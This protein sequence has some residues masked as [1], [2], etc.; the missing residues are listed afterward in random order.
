MSSKRDIYALV[1][2]ERASKWNNVEFGLVNKSH[3]RLTFANVN[4][5]LYDVRYEMEANNFFEN[6]PLHLSVLIP[7]NLS[8]NTS[9]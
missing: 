7:R 6:S 4:M 8:L 9:R 2:F 1:W 5:N 3:A